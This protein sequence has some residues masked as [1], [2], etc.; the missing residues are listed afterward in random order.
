VSASTILTLA[1]GKGIDLLDPKP[2]DIDWDAYAEHLAKEKRYNGATPDVEYSVAEH[3]CRGVDGIM[4]QTKNSLLA[5]YF[6][7]HDVK[8]AALKDLTTPLKCAMAEIAQERYRIP[9][10]H[11]IDSFALLE[12]RHDVAIH[13]AAGL[14]WPM[15]VEI[16]QQVK[17]WDLIMFVT[18]WRDVMQGR[19]HPNWAPY[20]GIQAL[21]D[22]INP[23]DWRTAKRGLLRRWYALLPTVCSRARENVDTPPYRVA[24]E[25]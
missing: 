7:T 9:P 21:P 6:S 10:E 12:Y 11:V 18:E 16:A 8:E 3:I 13:A 4:A 19:P 15:T 5:A 23:W 22:K 20:S 25:A 24:G 14:P 17:R 2:S 1:N